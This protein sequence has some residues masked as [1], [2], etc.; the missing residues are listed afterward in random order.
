VF[1][2]SN[3]DRRP[4][5]AHAWAREEYGFY[6]E[7]EWCSQRLFEVEEFAGAVWD[8][9]CGTGRIAEAARLAGYTTR[10]TDLNDRGYQ[11]FDGCLDFLRCDQPRAK[12][13][14]CNPPFDKCEQFVHRALALTKGNGKV[15]VIWLC[16]RLNAAHWLTDLPLARVYLLTPRPSMPPGHVIAAGEK[17]GG[18]RQ[19]FCWL[20]LS[21]KH[22]GRPELHWLYR[23]SQQRER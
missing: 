19:D 3:F 12:N 21:H 11:H 22:K 16:R 23:D 15:A 2:S 10:A 13:V 5:A 9:S 6:V 17:P 4:L 1:R 7:P 18:G 20:V 14:V 8:P